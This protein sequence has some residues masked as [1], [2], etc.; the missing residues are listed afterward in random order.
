MCAAALGAHGR[1]LFSDHSLT[2]LVT[3][4]SRDPVSPPQLAADAPVADVVGPVEIGLLH[5]LGDQTDLAFP[6]SL[7]CGL[8][9]FIHLDEPLLLDQRLNGSAASVMGSY[10]VSIVLDAD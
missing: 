8:N 7:D 9:E 10:V 5:P 6:D 4:V 1:R 3:V 2:A